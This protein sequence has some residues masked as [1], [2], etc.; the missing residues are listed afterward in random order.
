ML[1]FITNS[2]QDTNND[3]NDF[4]FHLILHHWTFQ[5]SNVTLPL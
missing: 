1:L 3:S 2:K 4:F 5:M